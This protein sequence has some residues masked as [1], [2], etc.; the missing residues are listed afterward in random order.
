M[1]K[2]STSAHGGQG[3]EQG[4]FF[5]PNIEVLA[6]ANFCLMSLITACGTFYNA[7]K[8]NALI[9][10]ANT[11]IYFIYVQY[12]HVF[13]VGV[14]A[15]QGRLLCVYRAD[16][17]RVTFQAWLCAKKK[18]SPRGFIPSNTTISLDDMNAFWLVPPLAMTCSYVTCTC[19]PPHY[20]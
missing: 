14:G 8:Q 6:A 16:I 10:I 18:S 9:F 3:F 12:T 11:V 5:V 13:A 4:C 20:F 7:F 17:P 19:V 1:F 15:H 2:R